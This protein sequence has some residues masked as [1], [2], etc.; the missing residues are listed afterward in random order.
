MVMQA[1]TPASAK[2]IPF[3][4][5]NRDA[6]HDKKRKIGRDIFGVQVMSEPRVRVRQAFSSVNS[7]QQGTG[8]SG[9][10]DPSTTPG[11]NQDKKMCDDAGTPVIMNKDEIEALL[12]LKMKGKTKFDFK[13]KSEQMMEYIKRLRMC[14]RGLQESEASLILEKEHLIKQM[15]DERRDHTQ[16][17]ELLRQKQ[18][19]LENSILELKTTIGAL[20]E[21]LKSLESQKQTLLA[22]RESDAITLKKATAEIH[23]L[24]DESN[25]HLREF[26][27]A[28]QQVLVLQDINKRLQEYNTSLQTYNSKLQNDSAAVAESLSKVQKEKAVVMETLSNVRA[29]SVVLQE[30]LNQA[31]ASLQ[32]CANEK[33]II[34]DADERLKAELQNAL[35]NIK[36]K[37]S[38]I[39]LLSA[40][41][42]M[43]KETTGKSATELELLNRKSHNLEG[44][45]ALQLEELKSLRSQ[46]ELA[47]HKIQITEN[48][49]LHHRSDGMEKNMTIEELTRRLSE[50]EER[51]REGELLRKKL[52][53]TI[54]ELKGNIRV[55]C[56]VRPMLPDDESSP[57]G[58]D[59]VPVI[60]YP[61]STELL[62]HGIELIQ[63][64]GQKH[65]F[66]FDKVFGPEA[67]QEDIFV[68]IS[69]LIQSALDGYKVCIFAYGQTGSGKT[70]TMLGNPDDIDQ[71][72]VIPRSLEQIFKASQELGA[73]G[74]SFQMQASMLEIY[75]ETIRDLL[76]PTSKCET[77]GKQY[78]VKH[79]P[80]GNTSVSDLTLVEVTKWKEVSSLLQRASQS[81]SVSKTAM[82]EQSSR[83]HCVF[84]LRI[85]G[86][87][88]S[89]D[90]QVNGV[91]NLIDLAGSERLSRSCVSG[92]RLKETQA[93]NKSLAS[94]GDVILAIANKEQHIPYRN[95]KLTYLLQPCL[96]G[97]SK[98]LMFVNISPDVKS[99]SESLCSLRFAAKVN[100][101]EIGVPRRNT[102]TRG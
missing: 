35:N 70:Y 3:N 55:F 91:L 39:E 67:G 8:Q 56:R 11:N 88:E 13:G 1:K 24:T 12:N 2:K 81:R 74:W 73:Q 63:A 38:R 18:N 82:N 5:E 19:E 4:K 92:D 46:L 48:A 58:G 45:Y 22:E 90:Q 59:D 102:L 30:Q 43:F 27:N 9:E 6:P 7:R 71:R 50:S 87:N 101:C 40:E 37:S 94:L 20:E 53:N 86:L 54:L 64:Q 32:E 21:K 17:E 36:E 75:N 42:A 84:T 100:A 29:H 34:M 72:G 83:S 15:H 57:C 44:K 79:D 77:T 41:N 31:K 14:I 28:N 97:D 69:Q 26:E 62:G 98:T 23:R 76:A 66:S 65:T 51:V 47:N 33:K 60:Q 78:T 89:I 99:T 49:L 95:S 61:T 52:H 93:I 25:T 96:G 68:E 10:K 16:T 80:N 85:S